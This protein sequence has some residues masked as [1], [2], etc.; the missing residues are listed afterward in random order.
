MVYELSYLACKIVWEVI[1]NSNQAWHNWLWYV[2]DPWPTL[3]RWRGRR[4]EQYSNYLF[5]FSF[6]L[7]N[8]IS[9]I[10][11]NNYSHPHWRWRTY[12]DLQVCNGA[13]QDPKLPKGLSRRTFNFKD[14]KMILKLFIWSFARLCHLVLRFSKFLF[15]SQW[16]SSSPN[17]ENCK[18]ATNLFH[19]SS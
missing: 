17:V 4:L 18:L 14:I 11:P 3:S 13:M 15:I 6:Y 7:F 16:E 19:H 2:I 5:S 10:I 1:S 12:S 9:K 8:Y